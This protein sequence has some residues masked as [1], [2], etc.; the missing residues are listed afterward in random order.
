M[1]SIASFKKRA[2]EQE[3]GSLENAHI[4]NYVE[5]PLCIEENKGETCNG[6]VLLMCI[7]EGSQNSSTV[8]DL[9]NFIECKQGKDYYDWLRGREIFR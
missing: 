5:L 9:T 2:Q 7:L 4:V 6:E 1:N 8:A 3:T